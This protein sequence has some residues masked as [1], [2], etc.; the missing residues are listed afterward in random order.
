[1]AN[2]YSFVILCLL[3]IG[4]RLPKRSIRLHSFWMSAV[5]L[6]DLAL[7]GYLVFGREA[8]T[9]IDLKMPALLYVHLAF[10]VSTVLLYFWAM[11]VGIQLLKGWPHPEM[12][13][14]LDRVIVP[15]RILT[16]VTSV[17]LQILATR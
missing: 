7:I 6:A 15:C 5:I 8:L 16:F 2:L 3:L 13:R 9:K 10:A 4:R 17:L 11:F 14:A 12:M 1:M